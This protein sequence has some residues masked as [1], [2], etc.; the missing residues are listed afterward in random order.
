M[1][2]K[3]MPKLPIRIIKSNDFKQVYSTGASGGHSVYDFRIGFF[4]DSVGI[5]ESGNINTIERKTDVEIIL[6]PIAA[7]ELCKWLSGNIT[8]FENRFGKINCCVPDT[9]SKKE[10]DKNVMQG[11]I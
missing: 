8:M 2:N 11:Y 7:V 4:T 1:M 10:D 5:D 3:S 6:S 9:E